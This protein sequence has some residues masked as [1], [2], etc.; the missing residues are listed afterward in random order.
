[1][2]V[3]KNRPIIS[4]KRVCAY[5]KHRMIRPASTELGADSLASLEVKV[6]I[7][8]QRAVSKPESKKPSNSVRIASEDLLK[9]ILK[10]C[11]RDLST[12]SRDT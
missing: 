3:G 11:L 12:R 4:Q 9:Q 7:G 5:L 2:L 6:L 8:P 1:M 10:Q